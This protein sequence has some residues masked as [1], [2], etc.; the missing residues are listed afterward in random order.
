MLL[1]YNANLRLEVGLLR[2]SEDISRSNVEVKED[3]TK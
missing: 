3:L 1:C 2:S